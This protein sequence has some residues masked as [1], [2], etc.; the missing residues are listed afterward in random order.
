L[1]VNFPK[2]TIEGVLCRGQIEVKNLSW[3]EKSISVSMLSKEDQEINLVLPSEIMEISSSGVSV[4]RNDSGE[5]NSRKIS[6]ESGKLISLKI[7]I[8]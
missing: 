5:N 4:E 6:L 8:H 1:S 3:D 7:K 2:G